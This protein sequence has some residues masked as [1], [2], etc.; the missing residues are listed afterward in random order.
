MTTAFQSI[1]AAIAAQLKAAPALAGGR[2]YANRL[3]PLPEGVAT[4]VVVRLDK[5]AASEQVLGAL[6]WTSTF[7]LECYARGASGID[8][9]DAVDAL[10]QAAWARLAATDAAAL[11]AMAFVIN[12]AIDWIYDEA[13]GPVVCA[14]VALQVQHRTA[15]A[16][17]T[18]WS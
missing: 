15:V 16:T 14:S 5:S 1:A 2:V 8:P 18:A 13:D 4:A 3:R 17:L 10:L 11:G 6:D 12:P 9:A 7:A